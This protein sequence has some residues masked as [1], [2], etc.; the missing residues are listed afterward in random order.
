MR[1]GFGDSN[2]FCV[3]CSADQLMVFPHRGLS[4]STVTAYYCTCLG[5]VVFQTRVERLNNIRRLRECRSRLW[6]H[7]LLLETVAVQ[8]EADSLF[9]TCSSRQTVAVFTAAGCSRLLHIRFLH[10]PGNIANGSLQQ[11]ALSS[12]F[13]ALIRWFLP[14]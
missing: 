9:H 2:K 11:N 6:P 4:E 10:T 14:P 13:I 7:H 1:G 3:S 12:M 8:M 5:V